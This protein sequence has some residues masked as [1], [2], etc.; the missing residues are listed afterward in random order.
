MQGAEIE[1]AFF[2]Q[3][4]AFGRQRIEAVDVDEIAEAL[5][6]LARGL[7]DEGPQQVIGRIGD[8][9]VVVVAVGQKVGAVA[10]LAG[11]AAGR[12][13]LTIESAR[14]IPADGSMRMSVR[15]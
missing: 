8:G 9:P 15:R 4:E 3:R 13:E 6:R 1:A 5:A 11:E 7:V 12:A 14:E 10:D 2:E